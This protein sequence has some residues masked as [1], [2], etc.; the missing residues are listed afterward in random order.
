MWDIEESVVVGTNLRAWDGR[1][2]RRFAAGRQCGDPDCD[3]YLSIYNDSD[4]CSVHHVESKRHMRG[5]PVR[6]HRR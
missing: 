4:F 6:P 2:P 5:R 3:T 1:P